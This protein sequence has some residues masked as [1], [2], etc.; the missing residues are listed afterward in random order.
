VPKRVI[1]EHFTNTYC[2]IC[3]ANNPN[4]Y[5]NLWN[6]PQ[7]IHISYYPSAP[8]PAC[9][10][11]QQNTSENDA[12]TQYYGIYG[13]TPKL[14]IQ[15][16]LVPFTSGFSNPAIYQSQL[17]QLTS[18][19]MHITLQL[20]GTDSLLTTTT[21]KK[22]DT[23]SL[24]SLLLYGGVAEDTLTFNA[25]NGETVHYDVFHKS[26]WGTTSLSITAPTNIGDSIVYLKKI[27]KNSTWNLQRFYAYAILQQT[28]KSVVQA[29]TSAHIS[30]T[31]GI[32]T[33]PSTDYLVY[34]NPTSDKIHLQLAEIPAHIS[35]ISAT[36]ITVYETDKNEWNT[37]LSL[38]D[39]PTGLYFLQI[40]SNSLNINTKI[41]KY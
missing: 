38:V 6:F 22:T 26:I 12:R 18:F 14:E 1:A 28:N 15:G 11:N 20:S 40:R 21:I 39:V 3:A 7:V 2:S 35:I 36:G 13:S 5:Q 4:L 17:N 31:T 30:S 10:I 32:G 24:T 27:A 33:I 19:D 8:Y 25:N 37:T 34:P 23:S 9:P 16:V 41:Y 29:A